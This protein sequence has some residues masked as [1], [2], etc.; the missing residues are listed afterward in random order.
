MIVISVRAEAIS[1]VQLGNTILMLTW[2]AS[3]WMMLKARDALKVK[4]DR[5]EVLKLTVR[6]STLQITIPNTSEMNHKFKH[7]TKG[8][9][10]MNYHQITFREIVFPA[11]CRCT[12]LTRGHRWT[13]RSA[14]VPKWPSKERTRSSKMN[15]PLLIKKRQSRMNSN[16]QF[17]KLSKVKILRWRIMNNK[18]NLSRIMKKR[19]RWIQSRRIFKGRRLLV[20]MT[21][22]N[23]NSLL[24]SKAN[25]LL[26]TCL[27][28]DLSAR[29]ESAPTW[30]QAPNLQ[31][32]SLRKS[33]SR[34]G[35]FTSIYLRMSFPF[36]EARAIPKSLGL[37]SCSRMKLLTTSSQK[38]WK[39]ESCSN[40]YKK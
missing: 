25:I 3:K 18:R 38:L 34:R 1:S 28:K 11:R 13:S 33:W 26:E 27:D 35:R 4:I 20:W 21:I 7:S 19:Y 5:M 40:V 36:L 9:T 8:M 31:S 17:R 32:K 23:S 16:F 39:V 6:E 22:R 12:N 37:S 10:S 30:T 14:R 15:K 29:C 24:I 2:L